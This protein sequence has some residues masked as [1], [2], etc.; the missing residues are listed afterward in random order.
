[1]MTT[2]TREQT[3]QAIAVLEDLLKDPTLLGDSGVCLY[4]TLTLT[5]EYNWTTEDNEAIRDFIEGKIPT[6]NERTTECYPYISPKG[7]WTEARK[8]LTTNVIAALRTA[9]IES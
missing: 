1:M 5:H 3:V 7:E 6:V 4:V 9:Y 8:Q 2:F